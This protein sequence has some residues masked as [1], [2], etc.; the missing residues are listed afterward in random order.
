MDFEK[1]LVLVTYTLCGAFMGIAFG[2]AVDLFLS[3]WM[4]D[5][6]A[7]LVLCGFGGALIAYKFAERS[8][9]P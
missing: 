2:L 5:G 7:F 4:N 1:R 8:L 6:A 9:F 3:F